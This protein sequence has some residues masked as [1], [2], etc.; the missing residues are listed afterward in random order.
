MRRLGA[1]ATLH[2]MQS[3]GGVMTAAAARA[4]PVQTL[5]SGPVGGT[6]GGAALAR[7]TGRRN[8]ICVDMG[9]TSC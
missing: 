6:I 5:L 4:Q 3:S 8:L 7:A 2:V 9:G 1:P